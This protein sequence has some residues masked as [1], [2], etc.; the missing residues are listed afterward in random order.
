MQGRSCQ[1]VKK[2]GILAILFL[3]VLAMALPALA[4]PQVDALAGH[5]QFETNGSCLVTLSI[6][7]APQDEAYTMEIPLPARAEEITVDGVQSHSLLMSQEQKRLRVE[8]NGSGSQ[9]IR[10]RYLLKGL[11]TSGRSGAYLTLPILSGL[12]YPI[13]DFGFSVTL[14][15]QVSGHPV[16]ESGY[17]HEN[18]EQILEYSFDG[19]TVT[20][21]SKTALKDRETL[22]M[23]LEVPKGFFYDAPRR[24]QAPD[25][26]D[27]TILTL[28]GLAVLYFI[29]TL[30]PQFFRRKRYFTVP[31][32]ITAGDVGTCL[33]GCGTDLTM[34]VLSWARMGYILIEMDNKNRVTLHKR[35]DMGNERGAHEVRWFKSLFGQRTMV[36]A[37]SYHYAKLCRKLATKSPLRSQLYHKRSGNPQIFRAVCV[38]AG[39][40]SGLQ[41]GLGIVESVGGKTLLGMLLAILCGALSYFIESGGK[42]LPLREKTPLWTAFGC[43]AAWLALGLLTGEGHQ[44]LLMVVFQ[45]LAGIGA[46]YG[47]KRSDTGL[48]YLSQIRGLRIHMTTT[49]TFDMQQLL[50]QNPDYFY[51]LAPYALA[52]G[53][54]RSFARRFGKA[55]LPEDSYLICGAA[56]EMTAAKWANRLRKAAD[57]LNQRQK[58]LPYEQLRGK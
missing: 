7:L 30:M 14:P 50:Q 55:T 52:L 41:M 18:V 54:D 12:E 44:T 34:L 51:E 42:C 5:F 58:R 37:D 43:A 10:V 38:L 48:R 57:I 13:S 15:A 29:L 27:V 33:T 46:A 28:I 36:D 25:G 3:C 8:L 20:G 26:W 4:A 24:F 31:E 49:S 47:G 40:L 1:S 11:L 9:H 16:F 6:A 21:K 39:T 17:H 23:T 35:M 56:R 53:V 19:Q 2:A 45:F 22:E 32:G